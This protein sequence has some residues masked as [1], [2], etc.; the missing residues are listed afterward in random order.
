MSRQT[1]VVQSHRT[2]L[3]ASWY[4]RCIESVRFWA[5]AQEF[6]YRWLGDELLDR[7]APELLEKTRRQPVV[8]TDLARLI[9]LEEALTEGYARVVWVD[10]DVLVLDPARLVL[11]ERPAQFGREVWVQRDAAGVHKVYRK[12]HNAFMAFEAGNP[13]LPFYRHSAERILNRYDPNASR[14][15]AQLIGPKLLTLL[16]NAIGFDVIESAAVLSPA[17]AKDVLEGGGEALRRFVEASAVPPLALNLCGSSVRGG[18]LGDEDVC[19]LV[20]CLDEVVL[21][22]FA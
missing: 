8:A 20:G 5:V 6:D 17:V 11:A 19:R 15:V 21:A 14:M 1:L 9:V 22:A 18:E 3:P 16:H 4:E 13:V 2:P 10:A 7:L 12:I